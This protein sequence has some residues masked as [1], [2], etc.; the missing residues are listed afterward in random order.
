VG[1]P[2]QTVGACDRL[3]PA[4][5]WEYIW[6]TAPS[7][8]GSNP[9]DTTALVAD[10]FDAGTVWVTAN[11]MGVFKST[12]CGGT[13]THVNTGRNGPQLDQGGLISMAVDPVDKGTMYI[14]PIYGAGGIW[15]STNG[16]VDWDQLI[17]P[18]TDAG[19][20]VQYNIYDSV[21]MDPQDHRHLVVG[22][23][24]DCMA[25]YAPACQ[26]ES[27]DAGATWTFL[28]LPTKGWEEGAGPWVID[29]ASW[30]YAGNSGL[31]LTTNHG[32][33][34]KDVTPAGAMAFQG[35]E[36]ETHSLFHAADG[37]FYL[38]SLSGIVKSSDAHT[39]SLIPNSGGRTVGFAM[40]GGKLFSSDQWS[41]SYHVAS[42]TD[43]TTW[44][45]LPPPP[46]LDPTQGA[47]FLAYDAAHH[48]LYSSNFAGGLWRVVT[49]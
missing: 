16:G 33:N 36:V 34:W 47:P 28:K 11:K 15:K 3:S 22:T 40:G 46:A 14:A 6:P 8:T 7:R 9:G 49:P 44:T 42:E 12:N 13:W 48:I 25:P 24:A 30:L 38:T 37:T 1:A 27:T 32:A 18:T 29:A 31:W 2:P 10:P 41:N 43:P 26:A 21:S 39:W 17:S 4:G 20:V 23:H 35:G 5:Q 19:K 45:K